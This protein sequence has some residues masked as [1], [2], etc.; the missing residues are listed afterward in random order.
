MKK[1][2]AFL[3]GLGG[4]KK[5]LAV[6]GDPR[7]S[8]EQLRKAAKMWHYDRRY[9][10]ERLNNPI[11]KKTG[12]PL[13]PKTIRKFE[14]ELRRYQDYLDH[15]KK[16]VRFLVDKRFLGRNRSE[17]KCKHRTRVQMLRK[18]KILFM[19]IQELKGIEAHLKRVLKKEEELD[20]LIVWKGFFPAD[21]RMSG[22]NNSFGYDATPPGE[23]WP[24]KEDVGTLMDLWDKGKLFEGDLQEMI[25]EN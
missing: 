23:D 4:V 21:C 18:A 11:S 17:K 20:T 13:T 15:W 10:N 12:K 22:Y 8:L 24:W 5:Y 9:L 7:E 19:A 1:E 14:N 3:Y 2:K 25:H 6:K 16:V